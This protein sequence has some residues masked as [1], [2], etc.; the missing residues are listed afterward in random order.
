MALSLF[1]CRDSQRSGTSVGNPTKT[2]MTVA[3]AR[4]AEYTLARVNIDSLVFYRCDDSAPREIALGKSFDLLDPEEIELPGGTYCAVEVVIG[5]DGTFRIDGTTTAGNTF[6]L[7]IAS[8]EISLDAGPSG[9]F[10]QEADWVIEFG[11]PEWI[12]GEDFGAGLTTVTPAD[13]QHEKLF[14]ALEH[15]SGFWLDDDGDG[16]IN[17]EERDGGPVAGE[18]RP[19]DDDD[20]GDEG[21][22]DGNSGGCAMAPTPATWWLLLAPMLLLRRRD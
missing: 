20:D 8:D 12:D 16:F 9:F 15:E 1:A 21:P 19:D 5:G 17:E 10:L 22:G 14:D 3:Q 7:T 4:L 18:Q 11:Q 2:T 13:L 6:D